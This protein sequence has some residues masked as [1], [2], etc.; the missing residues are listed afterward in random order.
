MLTKL[1]CL[2]RNTVLNFTS[3]PEFNTDMPLTCFSFLPE[4]IVSMTSATIAQK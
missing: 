4:V 1:W 2:I 3:C